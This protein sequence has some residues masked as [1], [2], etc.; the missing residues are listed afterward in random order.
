M[1]CSF[2][3][4]YCYLQGYTNAV[5]ICLPGNLDEILEKFS[6]YYRPGMRIGTGQFT[7][8]LIFDH[9]TGFSKKIID[10]FRQYLDVEFEFKTKSSNIEN[11]LKL[12]S[13]KN[14]LV[15]WSMNP[16]KIID[17]MEFFNGIITG[18]H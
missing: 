1:G 12:P 16:Q 15:S 6:S 14:V 11:I 4:S 2:D 8:S 5:G 17:D 18:A 9:L 10:H 7:D 3:C 13:T